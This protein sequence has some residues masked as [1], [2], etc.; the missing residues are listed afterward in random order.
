MR[1]RRLAVAAVA[2]A[3]LAGFTGCGG[4]SESPSTDAGK[5][6]AAAATSSA[7]ADAAAE[8]AAAGDKFADTSVRLDVTAVGGVKITGAVDATRQKIEST[9]NMG[10]LG[11]MAQRQVGNDLY[12]R[13]EGRIGSSIGAAPGKWMHIDLAQ[14]PATSALNPKNNDPSN[15]MR[16]LTTNSDVQRTGEHRFAGKLDL[17]KSTMVNPAALKSLGVKATAVPFTAQTDAE[18]RLTE[19]VLELDALAAGAGKMTAKYSDYGAPVT[20]TAPPTAQV[21]EMPA[22]FRKAMGA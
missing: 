2:V 6:P 18:G 16:M 12:V 7:P 20:V 15:A 17:T 5:S 9:T 14:V 11:K 4:K 21:V 8:L 3:A 19:L 10:A 13:A 22:K 1:I